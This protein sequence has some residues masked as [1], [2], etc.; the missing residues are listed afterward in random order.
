MLT[1]E[2][3]SFWRENVVAIHHH[4]AKGFSE[5]VVL[6]KQVIKCWKFYYFALGKGINLLRAKVGTMK[7]SGVS[8][9]WE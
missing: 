4:S 2:Q 1:R 8:N 9:F 3:A 6:A 7:L 5:S